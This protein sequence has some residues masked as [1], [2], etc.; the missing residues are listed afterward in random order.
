M[1]VSIYEQSTDCL[2]ELAYFGPNW[3]SVRFYPGYTYARENAGS[4]TTVMLV[5]MS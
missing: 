4:L 3:I 5:L 2:V 1:T